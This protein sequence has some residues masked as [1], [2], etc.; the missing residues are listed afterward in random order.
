MLGIDRTPWRKVYYN[1]TRLSANRAH[2]R[3]FSPHPPCH[4]YVLPHAHGSVAPN[5]HRRVMGVFDLRMLHHVLEVADDSGGRQV[6][7]ASRNQRLMHVQGDG[8]SASD[9]TEVEVALRQEHGAWPR[10]RL[11]DQVLG[12]ADVWQSIHGFRNFG[13]AHNTSIL[14]GPARTVPGLYQRGGI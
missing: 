8:E 1:L 3:T 9:T 5:E 14:C 10:H 13:N 6:A 7:A 2:R 12:T 11:G 4:A